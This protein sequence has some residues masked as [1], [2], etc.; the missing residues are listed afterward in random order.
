MRF[1][2]TTALLVS[3]L[4]IAACSGSTGQQ[5]FRPPANS[6]SGYV[7]ASAGGTVSDSRGD[8]V[9]ISTRALASDQ[10]VSLTFDSTATQRAPNP[11]WNIAHGMLTVALPGGTPPVTRNTTYGSAGIPT[12]LQV[13]MVYGPSEA[14]AIEAAAAP[15]V[16]LTSGAT[17]RRVAISGTFDAQAHAVTIDIPA[18]MLS[19]VTEIS[20][21]LGENNPALQAPQ[22]GG[23]IW[24]ASTGSWSTFNLWSTS[25]RTLIVIHGIFSSVESAYT[26][27]N[28]YLASSAG[29]SSA[30]P[31]AYQQILGFDYDYAQP[32]AVEGAKFAQFINGLNLGDFDIEAHS[33]G[34]LVT[35]AAL[36]QLTSQPHRTILAGGPLPLRGTP[37][38][39]PADKHLRN[40][41]LT[42]AEFTIASPAKIDEAIDSGMVASIATGSTTLQQLL[43]AVKAISPYPTFER[44][45]GDEEYDA[46]IPFNWMLEYYGVNA[47]AWDGVVEEQAALSTDMQATRQTTIPYPHMGLPCDQPAI[48]FVTKSP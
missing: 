9:V 39:L 36:P 20:I 18:P 40:V 24:S 14:T 13:H 1:V 15:L 27:A 29:G 31:Y 25:A 23:K 38:S 10:A 48:D 12:A 45:A 37:L 35:L 32:P 47:D 43:G 46:E 26:C 3:T 34:T 7:T 16:T 41:L 2:K 33:Y 22:L 8:S 19:S 30:A 5:D 28:Q 6:G 42:L 44:I 21:A 17:S 4:T 11:N